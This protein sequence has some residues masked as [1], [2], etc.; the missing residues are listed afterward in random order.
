MRLTVTLLLATA[1]VCPAD[2]WPHFRGPARDGTSA[3]SSRHHE[4]GWPPG[5]APWTAHNQVLA[6]A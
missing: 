5:D 1:I 6:R 4:S 3:E 2:D